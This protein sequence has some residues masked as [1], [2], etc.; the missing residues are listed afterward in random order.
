MPMSPARAVLRTP[1]PSSTIRDPV[2]DGKLL[3]IPA[4][5]VSAP[6][7]ELAAFRAEARNLDHPPAPSFSPLLAEA[8]PS[9]HPPPELG[10]FALRAP[11]A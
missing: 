9:L 1:I 3:N 11:P 8:G 10:S 2:H 7:D 6:E 5:S 4:R